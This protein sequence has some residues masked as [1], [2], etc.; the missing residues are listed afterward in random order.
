MT[1]QTSKGGEGGVSHRRLVLSIPSKVRY[2][3]WARRTTE[4][5]TRSFDLSP[6]QQI[7][8]TLVAS[9]LVTNAIEHGAGGRVRLEIWA[10]PGSVE[11][12]ASSAIGDEL[13]RPTEEW[14]LPE[15]MARSG[16]GLAIIRQLCDSV[17]V[18]EADDRLVITCRFSLSGAA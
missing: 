18:H 15:P 3:R 17:Q 2:L 11:V 10:E 1:L 6:T 9:E 8:L 4:E 13:P 16:R 5:G 12:T 14:L 7:D